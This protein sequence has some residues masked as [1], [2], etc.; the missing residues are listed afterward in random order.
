M[1]IFLPKYYYKVF[2]LFVAI[3]F[4]FNVN[5]QRAISS[6]SGQNTH[7]V[8]AGCTPDSAI[9]N[10]TGSTQSFIVPACV[11]SIT[12]RAWGGGGGGAGNDSH[13]GMAG[14]GGAYASSTL[15]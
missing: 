3:G 5:G 7:Q 9:F 6:K 12:V 10:Y 8:D 1:N 13:V 4:I 14:G 15:T 2:F 11:T